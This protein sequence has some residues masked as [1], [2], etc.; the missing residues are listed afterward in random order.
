MV[1]D[2]AVAKS[3]VR[4][5]YQGAVDPALEN[6]LTLSKGSDYRPYYTAAFFIFAEYRQL[7]RADEVNFS[8]D[9]L[10]AVKSLLAIQCNIDLGLTGIPPGF[11]CEEM[12]A[13]L[14]N[15]IYSPGSF[16]VSGMNG[17]CD[18]ITNTYQGW[19]M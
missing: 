16:M 10:N 3:I 6:I 1:M 9:K 17:T 13:Q 15:D 18:P 7:T 8:Y 2:I 11:T 14:D 5:F 12:L 4:Q 19:S